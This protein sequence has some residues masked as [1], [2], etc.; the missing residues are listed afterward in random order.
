MILSKKIAFILLLSLTLALQ[1]TE[2]NKNTLPSHYNTA[3]NS[4]TKV[5]QLAPDFE[6]PGIDGKPVKLSSLKGQ[7]VL[8]DFWAS[9]C[10]PCRKENPYT[11]EMYNTYKDKGFTV[12]SVSL[13]QNPEKWKKA[14]AT[15][16]L[17]WN[18]HAID[19]KG[20]QSEVAELYNVQ[21]IPATFLIDRDGKIMAEGLRGYQLDKYL[22]KMF[23]K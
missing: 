10:G 17:I 11:V 21:A 7:I 6:L 3:N 19:P 13:D 4:L 14:I 15:D 22:Q 23:K 12:F 1:T 2:A 16:N 8:L 5:G 9:W 18:N 20:W